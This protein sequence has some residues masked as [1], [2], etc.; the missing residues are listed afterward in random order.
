MESAQIKVLKSYPKMT[1]KLIMLYSRKILLTFLSVFLASHLFGQA[2]KLS[3]QES[4]DYALQNHPDIQNKKLGEKYAD[5]QVDE[6]RSIGIPQLNANVQF[7]NNIER[8]VFVFPNPATG[9]NEPIRIGNKYS[10]VGTL[11]ASW[12]ALDATYFVGLKAAE[13]FTELSRLQT[14]MTSRDVIVNV[15]KAYYLVL[16]TSENVSLLEQNIKTL[17]AILSQTEGY[18]KNGF[19]EKLDV[20]RLNLTLSNLN[21]QLEGLKDQ[22]GITEQLLKLNIGM[23]VDTEIELSDNLES[24]YKSSIEGY[25]QSFNPKE[26]I[27]YKLMNSQLQLT[28]LDK[29]RFELAKYP[30]LAFFANYQQNNFGE[31]IDFSKW[32][33]NS[34]WG[35]RVG[36]PIFSGFNNKAQLKKRSINMDQTVNSMNMFENAAKLEANQAIIRYDRSVKT[37][38][39]QKKNLELANEI[40]RISSV[41]LKEGIGSSLEITNAQQEVKTSQTNYLN[42]VYDLLN[43][44]IEL[45]KAFGKI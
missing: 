12:L 41:K 16:I 15:T 40:L 25:A 1:N 23:S 39:L 42:A 17:E 19:A 10:T 28:A 6:T 22:K 5:A 31:E 44:Q 45:K 38:E 30:N 35:F 9:K 26:R 13:G 7:V 32:Y 18:Y 43:A 3:L 33:G 27:E 34:F 21:I 4:V 24:L 11:S 36:I 8:Q 37:I 29:K 14:N 20:D 2:K